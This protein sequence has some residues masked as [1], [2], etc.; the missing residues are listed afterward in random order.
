MRRNLPN[1]IA[2][3]VPTI[4]CGAFMAIVQIKK[5]AEGQPQ[6]AIMAALGTETYCKIV[7]VVDEDVDI[8]NLSDV[9]WAVAT[10]AGAQAAI[11]IRHP[12]LVYKA[13]LPAARGCQ[14]A[15]MG[16]PSRSLERLKPK[17]KHA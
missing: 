12:D 8:F 9:M 10:R 5:T 6:Q 2:V 7:V 16:G 14:S 15:V 3:H 13:C 1:I 11:G 17:P 4:T